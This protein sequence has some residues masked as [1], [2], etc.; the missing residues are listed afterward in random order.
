MKAGKNG[1]NQSYIHSRHVIRQVVTVK[2]PAAIGRSL[3]HYVY[4]YVDPRD[5]SIFYVGRGQGSRAFAHL[6]SRTEGRTVDRL[7]EIAGAGLEPGIE[8]VAHGLRD[9][10]EAGRVEAALID[11]LGGPGKLT[12]K[13]RG[14][15][16][17]TLGR[18][19]VPEVIAHYS[20]KPANIG[21]KALIIRINKLFRYGMSEIDLYD[22]TRGVWRIGPRGRAEA[23]IVL[24]VYKNIV[25]EVY[26]VEQWFP[27]GTTFYANRDE[28]SVGHP[29][30][31][32]RWEFVGRKAEKSIRNKY[33]HK[34]VQREI[35]AKNNPQGPIVYVN[36]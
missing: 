30:A 23:E 2:F 13:V 29:G 18:M 16:A 24:A 25:Q 11:A 21:E 10:K 1:L 4:I 26:W 34:S 36:F 9:A 20:R 6:S 33:R 12:N 7:E 22:A 27:A 15:D 28:S 5:L 14:M 35:E 8:I 3:G 17:S 32:D 31:S 19:T